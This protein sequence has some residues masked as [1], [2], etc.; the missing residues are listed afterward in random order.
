MGDPTTDD[1]S[2]RPRFRGG[3]CGSIALATVL[4]LGGTPGPMLEAGRAGSA[5][6]AGSQ[7][8]G[9]PF[10]FTSL[11]HRHAVAGEGP[12]R[13]TVRQLSG[14]API[15]GAIVYVV[16]RREG[17]P[18]APQ[19]TALQREP[20]GVTWSGAIP[21]QGTGSHIGYHFELASRERRSIRHPAHENAS[22]VMR[23][24]P[25][26]VR[27]VSLPKAPELRQVTMTVDAPSPPSGE[28]VVRRLSASATF[29]EA[30]I[31]LSSRRGGAGSYVLSGLLPPLSSGEVADFYFEL[32]EGRGTTTRVPADAPNQVYTLKRSARVVDHLGAGDGP[33]LAVARLGQERWLAT[34]G[35]GA[36]TEVDGRARSWGLEDDSRR[37]FGAQ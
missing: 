25:L 4:L 5:V 20:D 37:G 34:R 23:V 32:R 7:S 16:R 3:E 22:Y 8:V 19:R 31:R 1:A 27:V 18:S 9:A 11:R 13:V 30:R 36:W 33:V 15:G 2:N 12:Y 14:E 10:I 29:P 21:Q 24:V 28:V 6:P 17:A 26:R 35:S